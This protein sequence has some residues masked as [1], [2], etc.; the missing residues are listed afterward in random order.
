MIVTDDDAIAEEARTYRDQ[1]KGSFLANFHTR[2]GA[3]WRMSEPH[4]AIVLSQLAPA[5]RVHRRAPGARQALRRRASTTS[6]CARSRI[7]ADAH[8]NYYKYIAF[9]PDGVDRAALK[10]TCASE[11]D[12]GLSGEVYDTPL[13]Q[14]PVFDAVRRSAAARRRVASAR[15]TSAYRCTR[16]S[17]RA[18]P[19]TSSS[20]SATALD[21]E[22]QM[23]GRISRARRP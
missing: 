11:F 1:G 10:Q 7:P 18:T 8:C 3:N 19:T 6:A 5:R 21:R 9:L 16:R 4:A 20:P 15:A 12:I 17:P 13:H 23:R 14:Q 2:L 22:L